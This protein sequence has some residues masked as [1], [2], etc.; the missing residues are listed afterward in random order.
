MSLTE[1][2]ATIMNTRQ[3]GKYVLVQYIERFKQDN[4]IVKSSIGEKKLD[5]FVETNKKFKKIDEVDDEEGRIKMNKNEF[6]VW[7]VMVFLRVSDKGKYRE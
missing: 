5:H 7:S 6:G 4:L 1:S 3:Q 2:L